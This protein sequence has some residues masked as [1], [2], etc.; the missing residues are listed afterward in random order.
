M[1]VKFIKERNI[2]CTKTILNVMNNT[3]P[4][5]NEP[6]KTMLNK[7]AI[8]HEGNKAGMN[9]EI[10]SD[11]Q[12][13]NNEIISPASLGNQRFQELLPLCPKRVNN[14]L[15]SVSGDEFKTN[16]FDILKKDSPYLDNINPTINKDQ[17]KNTFSPNQINNANTFTPAPT[18]TFNDLMK[19]S[20]ALN[21]N[22]SIDNQDLIAKNS[23]FGGGDSNFENKI[24]GKRFQDLT[25]E[26]KLKALWHYVR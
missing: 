13:E 5:N 26:D 3:I 17:S 1:L 18:T 19:K 25:D 11:K 24:K 7:Q 14:K 12:N 21:N 8:G 23:A 6:G 2:L 15:E 9:V 20:S 10:F 4:R 16:T 22:V